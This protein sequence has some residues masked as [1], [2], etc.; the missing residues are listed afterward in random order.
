M[1]PTVSKSIF[2][3]IIAALLRMSARAGCD[4]PRR[5]TLGR[6]RRCR[7]SGCILGGQRG[8]PRSGPR[9]DR[10]DRNSVALA[11]RRHVLLRTHPRAEHILPLFGDG[12]RRS[13]RFGFGCSVGTRVAWGTQYVQRV[14][15]CCF[16]MRCAQWAKQCCAGA[17]RTSPRCST[18]RRHLPRTEQR[19]RR[20]QRRDNEAVAGT[21]SP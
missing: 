17:M 11:V 3:S 21:S 4:P 16:Q 13:V 8:H 7:R 6:S 15:G 9:P 10:P 18:I 14:R 1:K 20:W 19:V 5:R 12:G 2:V